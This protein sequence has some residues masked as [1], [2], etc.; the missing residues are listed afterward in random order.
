MNCG[1]TERCDKMVVNIEFY[2]L[3]FLWHKSRIKRNSRW[4]VHS[5]GVRQKLLQKIFVFY[6]LFGVKCHY[7]C[8][9]AVIIDLPAKK[10]EHDHVGDHQKGFLAEELVQQ[11][12]LHI[13]QQFNWMKIEE[14]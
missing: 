1:R 11:R 14:E 9:F 5:N 6:L 8:S 3:F 10:I 7:Y 2:C 12:Y 4:A 13:L